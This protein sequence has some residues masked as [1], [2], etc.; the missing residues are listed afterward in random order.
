MQFCRFF[1]WASASMSVL[2]STQLPKIDLAVLGPLY[3][4]A[5]NASYKAF[6]NAKAQA[7]A[8]LN[9]AL[10][11]GANMYGSLDNQTTSFSVLVFDLTSDE[12]LF[13]F[14]F[15]APGLDGSLTKGNLS[16]ETIY[17]T[18]SVGKLLTMYTWMV[19][20]GDS[21]FTDPITKYIP[22]LAQA[23]TK[24]S[25]SLFYTNWSEVTIGSLA[26]Q[27]SGIGVNCKPP[28]L[29]SIFDDVDKS[30]TVHV[31]D[32]A[33]PYITGIPPPEVIPGAISLGYP[34]VDN[35][36]ITQC[37]FYSYYLPT[38]TRK[39]LLNGIIHHPPLY[40]SYSSPVYSNVA[41]QILALA[42]EE[43]TGH[44]INEG[45]VKIYKKLGM[46]STSPTAPG[47]NANTIIPYNTTFSAFDYEL[48]L[49][50]P[51]GGQYTSTKDL[52]TFGRAI[53]KSTLMPSYVTRR[54][55]KPVTF[56]SQ[57]LKSVGA[58]WEI[59][60]Y[61]LPANT[62]I[63][64]S[65]IVDMYSKSGDIGAYSTFFGVVPDFGVGL[66]VLAA[67]VNP[68][69]QI[70]P[71]RDTVVEIF[72]QAAEA[73]AK[74]QARRAFT[75]TFQATNINSSITLGVDGG[76]GVVIQEWISNGT[77]FLQNAY[78]ASY[79]DFRLYP[80]ELSVEADS[81]TYYTYHLNFLASDGEP[82]K[83]DF[84]SYNN[85][86]WLFLDALIYKNLATDDFIIGFDKDGIVQSVQSAAL[87]V[88]MSRSE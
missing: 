56:T 10:A 61:L 70:S 15:E 32:L 24:S 17:R 73:S 26:S 18:G 4:P 41:Y 72:Y 80:T 71:V 66:S 47:S 51:S 74:E 33:T 23:A 39:Q 29:G 55:L 27:M 34:P 59:Q 44:S 69:T 81:I 54:W 43:V 57:L 45:Q 46:T 52:A 36:T 31:G 53:L 79:D 58:P 1:V 50:G 37:S 30:F 77:N 21:V 83:G 67:G 16:D 64:A 40:P 82:A 86:Y 68:H 6:T 75:G 2:A 5:S 11:N 48:G 12:P 60:R 63:N 85:D 38:C 20:I 9:E 28:V 25:N 76:P 8:A 14:H 62:I 88:S 35:D 65:H 87:R 84:W 13:D 19:D 78:L 49:A 3:Q 42:Y 22:E 7:L